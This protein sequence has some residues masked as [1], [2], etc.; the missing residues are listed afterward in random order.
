[1]AVSAVD[2]GHA[3]LGF[4]SECVFRL[5]RSR[6]NITLV[7]KAWKCSMCEGSDNSLVSFTFSSLL[8][9]K[10]DFIIITRSPKPLYTVT[11]SGSLCRPHTMHNIAFGILFQGLEARLRTEVHM[12]I[13]L[14]LKG[15]P[16]IL[17]APVLGPTIY[18][19]LEDT[20]NQED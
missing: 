10:Q 19:R 18:E 3:S 20:C 2:L 8:H 5:E 11:L 4:G 17:G 9:S 6:L 7:P 14:P 15:I 13:S 16:S 1:M 12:L